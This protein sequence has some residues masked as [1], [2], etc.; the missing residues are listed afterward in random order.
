MLGVQT[1]EHTEWLGIPWLLLW[2]V[3]RGTS[4]VYVFVLPDFSASTGLHG[5]HQAA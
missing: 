2:R 3:A 4:L 1:Q 5:E